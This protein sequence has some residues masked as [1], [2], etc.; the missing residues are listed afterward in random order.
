MVAE[1][2]AAWRPALPDA[3]NSTVG[4]FPRKRIGEGHAAWNFYPWQSW[5]L[6]MRSRRRWGG[7]PEATTWGRKVFF[8]FHGSRKSCTKRQEGFHAAAAHIRPTLPRDGG[9]CCYFLSHLL[10]TVYLKK[11]GCFSGALFSVVKVKPFSNLGLDIVLMM[12]LGLVGACPYKL[13]VY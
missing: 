9:E 1:T 12:S 3:I 4:T 2:P 10:F 7:T 13:T 6:K 11:L 5:L 8:F